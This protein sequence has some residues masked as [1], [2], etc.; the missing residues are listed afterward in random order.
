MEVQILSGAPSGCLAW[1]STCR[2]LVD[3]FFQD[4]WGV[5]LVFFSLKKSTWETLRNPGKFREILRK[6]FEHGMRTNGPILPWPFY[7][8]RASWDE[9]TSQNSWVSHD[10]PKGDMFSWLSSSTRKVSSMATENV[11]HPASKKSR[12]GWPRA[13]G[14]RSR[15]LMACQLVKQYKQWANGNILPSCQGETMDNLCS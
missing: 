12:L 13:V 9:G 2:S 10:W 6:W 11:R 7:V 4:I 1:R 8:N 15:W 5:F 3:V 14:G